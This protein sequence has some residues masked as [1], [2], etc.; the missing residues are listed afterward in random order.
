VYCGKNY[1]A[2]Q[3]GYMELYS[4]QRVHQLGGG[5]GGESLEMLC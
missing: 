2:A 4:D 5:G 3:K 1:V